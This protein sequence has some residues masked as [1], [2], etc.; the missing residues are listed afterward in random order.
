MDCSKLAERLERAG[1]PFEREVPLSGLTTFRIGGPCRV[2]AR[3]RTGEEAGFV[4]ETA[5]DAGIP[6]RSE[7]HTSELQ[8]P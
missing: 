1:I 2:L 5:R 7:E 6:L 8:S 4:L 3:P